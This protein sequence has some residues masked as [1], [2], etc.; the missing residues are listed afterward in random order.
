MCFHPAHSK[1]IVRSISENDFAENSHVGNSH[2]H[3]T[4]FWRVVILCSPGWKGN[5]CP[6]YWSVAGSACLQLNRAAFSSHISLPGSCL[7][8]WVPLFEVEQGDHGRR[9][10]DVVADTAPCVFTWVFLR[11]WSDDLVAWPAALE[12]WWENKD[13]GLHVWLVS[14]G[15]LLI[16]TLIELFKGNNQML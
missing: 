12:G 14:T 1:Q 7:V 3:D 4:S 8:G 10:C 5:S 15:S 11:L 6:F 16:H 13:T 2:H 9:Q